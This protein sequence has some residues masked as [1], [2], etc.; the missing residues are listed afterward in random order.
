[1]TGDDAV[2]GRE[3]GVAVRCTCAVYNREEKYPQGY[4]VDGM[5]NG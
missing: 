5:T 4:I 3:E 2:M 1:V